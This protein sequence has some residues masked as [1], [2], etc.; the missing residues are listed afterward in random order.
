MSDAFSTYSI[1]SLRCACWDFPVRSWERAVRCFSA[2]YQTSIPLKSDIFLAPLLSSTGPHIPLTKCFLKWGTIDAGAEYVRGGSLPGVKIL[3]QKSED[4]SHLCR[5]FSP[6]PL[7]GSKQGCK[8]HGRVFY[9]FQT[10]G[11]MMRS[12]ILNISTVGRVE[13]CCYVDYIVFM[14]SN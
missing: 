11:F 4:F 6:K 3:G 14:V 7:F 13:S 9:F 12:N 10:G 5:Y 2:Y 8:I 1:L